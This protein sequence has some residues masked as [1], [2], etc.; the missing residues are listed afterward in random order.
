M[1]MCMSLMEKRL[2]LLLDADRWERVSRAAEEGHRSAASVI[3][4]AIDVYFAQDEADA[5]RAEAARRFLELVEASD[6]VV[7]ADEDVA[8]ALDADL[9]AYLDKKLAP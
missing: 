6:M 9:D 8:A 2:Q 5:R 1:F 7:A 3:R 4:E